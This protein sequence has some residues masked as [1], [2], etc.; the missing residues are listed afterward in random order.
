MILD[1]SFRNENR[2]N[3]IS[4]FFWIAL[5][6]KGIMQLILSPFFIY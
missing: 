4:N 5:D 2:P 6:S 1:V 3:F